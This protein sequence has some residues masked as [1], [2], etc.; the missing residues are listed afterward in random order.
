MSCQD[1]TIFNND[2]GEDEINWCPLHTHAKEL[3]EVLKINHTIIYDP[4]C[5]TC[6][7]IKKCEG[8]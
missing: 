1:C 2:I 4:T 7:L 5:I 3:L 8:K 6:R